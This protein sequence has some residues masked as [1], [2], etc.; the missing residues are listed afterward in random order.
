MVRIS[1]KGAIWQPDGSKRRSSG[2]LCEQEW[3]SSTSLCVQ[4]VAQALTYGTKS[5]SVR[6]ESARRSE[7][8]GEVAAEILAYNKQRLK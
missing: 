4:K 7:I 8:K 3:E 5:A 2:A 6:A 1:E